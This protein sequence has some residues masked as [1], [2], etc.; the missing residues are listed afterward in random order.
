MSQ[1]HP[2]HSVLKPIFI[3]DILQAPAQA[4]SM[5]ID[6][7]LPDLET[8][9]PV[10]GELA[11]THQRNY[12]SVRA[13]AT[14]ITTLTCDRCLCQYNYRLQVD[15]VELIWLR[16]AEEPDLAAQELEFN[17][18]DELVESLPPQGYFEPAQWLY[19]Q[20]C[21]A[22]PLQKV[23]APD[24]EGIAVPVQANS[25]VAGAKIDQR[26]SALEILR[27]QLSNSSN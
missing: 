11:L 16:E 22:L 26:W 4:V 1:P 17:E 27:N 15:L 19:E 23:C 5:A 9:M 21:L 10:Q 7:Y 8:L 24:C 13:T 25:E 3:P 20:L 2:P 12:L 6:H 14:T 18:A